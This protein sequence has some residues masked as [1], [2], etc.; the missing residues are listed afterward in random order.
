M[1]SNKFASP[2]I[3][4]AFLSCAPNPGSELSRVRVMT[5]VNARPLAVVQN[6]RRC[7]DINS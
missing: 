1:M 4:Q 2:L 7:D 6:A 5:C 3:D